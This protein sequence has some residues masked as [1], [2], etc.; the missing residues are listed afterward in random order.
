MRVT[1]LLRT[2][3]FTITSIVGSLTI[4]AQELAPLAE[5]EWITG[6]TYAAMPRHKM[7]EGVALPIIRKVI[8]YDESIEQIGRAHV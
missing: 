5:A 3:A 7:A 1:Y 2:I 8:T 6:S 4:A